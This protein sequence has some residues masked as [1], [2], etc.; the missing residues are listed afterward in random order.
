MQKLNFYNTLCIR[1]VRKMIFLLQVQDSSIQLFPCFT[2][3][4]GGIKVAGS[5]PV[6]TQ[7]DIFSPLS[8]YS[9]V[10]C[11]DCNFFR[12]INYVSYAY[13]YVKKVLKCVQ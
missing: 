8:I 13:S 3:K 4:F 9:Q 11:I 12:E 5:T 7:R 10:I 6:P 1:Q 2:T